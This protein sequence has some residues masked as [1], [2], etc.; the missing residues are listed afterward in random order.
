MALTI[1]DGES[2]LAEKCLVKC[3]KH[4]GRVRDLRD[5]LSKEE[6]AEFDGL[7]G[8]WIVHRLELVSKHYLLP[9]DYDPRCLLLTLP[10]K[11]WKQDCPEITIHMYDRFGAI[12]DTV[13][14]SVKRSMAERLF[15]MGKRDLESKNYPRATQ[16]LEYALVN[17]A[18]TEDDD[19]LSK[20]AEDLKLAIYERLVKARIA[21]GTLDDIK[22]ASDLVEYLHSRLGDDPRVLLFRV[23]MLESAPPEEFDV[24]TF[25]SVLRKMTKSFKF[26][27]NAFEWM[28]TKL[29]SL[30]NRR[31][32]AATSIL[33]DFLITLVLSAKMDK[34]I[35]KVLALRI[36]MTAAQYDAAGVPDVSGPSQLQPL[37][38]KVLSNLMEPLSAATVT[39]I[40]S[41]RVSTPGG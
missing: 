8:E 36:R 33:D 39:A 23:V 2:N 41:V 5:G 27:A 37:L 35:V 17:V 24:D 28:C 18:E 15:E 25:A 3:A 12:K 11:A 4:L 22:K 30:S 6:S 21:L 26:T 14:A 31:P 29:V 19:Q 20:D 1:D 10:C 32:Q 7:D 9:G 38:D 34:W 16:W 40:Q 13:D